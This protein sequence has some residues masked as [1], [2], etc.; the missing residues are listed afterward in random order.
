[1]LFKKEVSMAKKQSNTDSDERIRRMS[2]FLVE[3]KE[4]RSDLAK[5]LKP[6]IDNYGYDVL[7]DYLYWEREFFSKH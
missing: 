3:L 4:R 5:K 7:I 1:V 2:E 6:L